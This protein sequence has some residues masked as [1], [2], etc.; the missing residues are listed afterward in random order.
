VESESQ[1]WIPPIQRTVATEG[2]GVAQLV[3]LIHQHRDY[4]RQSGEWQQRERTRLQ[5][6]LDLMLQ[7][8]LVDRWR[9]S[10]SADNYQRVVHN[11]V[12][13]EISPWQAVAILLDGEEK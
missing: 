6:E 3:G 7:L 9:A 12:K 1:Q 11:L 8:T 2:E 4:L 10:I 5:S 13:R